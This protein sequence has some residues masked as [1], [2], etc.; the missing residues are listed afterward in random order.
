MLEPRLL[1]KDMSKA[2]LYWDKGRVALIIRPHQTK[3]PSCENKRPM[4]FSAPKNQH[5]IKVSTNVTQGCWV[6]PK[7]AFKLCSVVHMVPVLES[8]RVQWVKGWEIFLYGKGELLRPRLEQESLYKEDL[9][10]L[11]MMEKSNSDFVGNSKMLEVSEP[12]DI[13]KEELHAWSET[14]LR[15][16]ERAYL[17]R[18]QG[19]EDG[20]I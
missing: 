13:F 18:Y 17:C 20:A 4:E 3:I 7:L 9:R 2:W 8:W 15:E 1:Q 16:I 14:T 11:V 6:H 19:W 12:W 5:Q 10:R